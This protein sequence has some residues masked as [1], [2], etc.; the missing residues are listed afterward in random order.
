MANDGNSFAQLW[1]NKTGGKTTAAVNG[2]TTYRYI[3]VVDNLGVFER[4]EKGLRGMQRKMINYSADGSY[5]YPIAS[6]GVELL[7][8]FPKG[9]LEECH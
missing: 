5:N 2:Q 4:L 3:N 8:F 9:G 7:E 1:A 6:K